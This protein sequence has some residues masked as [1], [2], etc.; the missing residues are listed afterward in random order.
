MLS[1]SVLTSQNENKN[2]QMS[3]TYGHR[4]DHEKRQIGVG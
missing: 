4:D 1:F 2:D 3:E